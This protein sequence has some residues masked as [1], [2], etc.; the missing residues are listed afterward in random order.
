MRNFILA[1]IIAFFGF[2]EIGAAQAER[3]PAPKE[4]PILT[5]S[6]NISVTNQGDTAVFDRAMLE[7]VGTISF[8]TGTPWYPETVKFEGV[9]LAKLMQYLGAKGEHIVV[10][11]L[12]DY[13]SDIPFTDIT[14]YNVILATKQ[15]GQYMSV[16]DKGPI[17]IVYPFDSDPELKHQT[18]YG[19]SVWQVSR[20]T[21]K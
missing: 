1:A 7:A 18:Y 20:I 5:V 9:P 3:L 19:R 11:A 21:V 13:S 2:S 6:G 14:K 16:R 15:N 17:F 4:K 12:N 8:E 10:T